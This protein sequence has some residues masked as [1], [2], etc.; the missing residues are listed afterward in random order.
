MSGWDRIRSFMAPTPTLLR[1]MLLGL[2]VRL[3]LAPWTSFPYDTYPFYGAA[4]GTL[5]GIGPYG[6]VL[7][8]YPPLFSVMMYPLFALLS[9]FMDPAEFGVFLPSMVEVSRATGMLVPFVTSPPFNLVMKLPLILGDLL[10]GLT[11]YRTMNRWS[12]REAGERAFLVWFLNPLVIFISSIH[13]QFDVLAAYCALLGVLAF[14]DRQYLFSGAVLGIGVLLKIFPAYLVVALSIALLL[15]MIKDMRQGEILRALRPS[16]LFVAG[17]VLSLL[18]V[19]PFLM[20]S[21]S[22]LDYIF[23]RGTYSSVGG[24][25]IWFVSPLFSSMGE[26]GGG[27]TGIP[28]GTILLIAG[29][30]ITVT[31]SLFLLRKGRERGRLLLTCTAT[32]A[33][34]LVTQSMTN[35]QYMIWL[36]PFLILT[37]AEQP[38]MVRKVYA[39]TL[40]GLLYLFSLQSGFVFIYPLAQYVGWPSVEFLNG[41]IEA[42]FI[43]TGLQR[44]MVLGALG[45]L[46]CVVLITILQPIRSDL[47]ENA[48]E[49]LRKW[50]GP[51]A[52]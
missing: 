36:F 6:N 9:L 50:R 24:M 1:F 20:G 18:S 33:L 31:A 26:G 22:F 48:L 3:L 2:V 10:V 45:G 41:G 52:Q 23:R 4:V 46:G 34:V 7:Y 25:N 39:L 12:G 13:G 30:V 29:I 17:G 5:A 19:L 35:P 27:E 42:Y 49:R 32:M 44:A 16:L 28:F 47:M 8:T 37:S 11:L 21:S 38:R 51:H 40:I 15:D 43:G 14:M